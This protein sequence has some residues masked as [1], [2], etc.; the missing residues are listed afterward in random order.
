MYLIYIV[1]TQKNAKKKKNQ[2]NKYKMFPHFDLV[3]K[4]SM[5]DRTINLTTKM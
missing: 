4:L 5:C 2:R 3:Q 1:L